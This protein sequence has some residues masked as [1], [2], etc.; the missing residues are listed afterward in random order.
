MHSLDYVD[1]IYVEIRNLGSEDVIVG[2][3]DINDSAKTPA[4]IPQSRVAAWPNS[5]LR[6]AVMNQLAS[7]HPAFL[8]FCDAGMKEFHLHPHPFSA[9]TYQCLNESEY[10]SFL[11]GLN[12][13][14]MLNIQAQAPKYPQL[15]PPYSVWHYK[16]DRACKCRDVDYFEIRNGQI[17]AILEITGKLRDESHLQNSLK[18]IFKRWNLHQSMFRSLTKAVLAPAFF[19]VH[20]TR[21]DVFYVFD[22]NFSKV[23]SGAQ[24]S[25]KA[26]LN[27]L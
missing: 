1:N 3:F 23:F 12:N 20:T 14:A 11:Q 5:S 15:L 18:D 7:E 21:L 16:L 17:R 10:I 6:L 4:Q 24:A 27:R 2:F 25:Y 13:A 9:T 26:W 19:V 22:I 8:V